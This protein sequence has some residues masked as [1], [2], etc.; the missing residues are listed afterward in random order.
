MLPVDAVNREF[1]GDME[2]I[3]FGVLPVDIAQIEIDAAPVGE[4]FGV[5]FAE[6]QIVIDLFAGGNQV[7]AE[8]LVQFIGS[9]LDIRGRKAVFAAAVLVAVERGKALAQDLFQQ[10]A[11]EVAALPLAFLR[12]DVGVAHFLQEIECGLLA[13]VV[14]VIDESGHW[15][16]LIQFF[17]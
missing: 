17:R 7:A 3:V 11:V 8:R 12:R 2:H 14:F 15:Y 5:A 9:A 1:L 6:H 13:D 4:R 16:L 10:N